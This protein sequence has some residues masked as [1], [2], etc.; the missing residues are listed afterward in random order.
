MRG[1]ALRTTIC[2]DRRR[3]FL[4]R[5]CSRRPRFS[6]P[7]RFSVSVMFL[8][9][10]VLFCFR[11]I[12]LCSISVRSVSACSYF[13]VSVLIHSVIFVCVCTHFVC[14]CSVPILFMFLFVP[15]C[16]SSVFVL[17]IFYVSSVC[18]SVD[19]SSSPAVLWFILFYVIMCFFVF[20]SLRGSSSLLLLIGAG[21]GVVGE[22]MVLLRRRFGLF[23]SVVGFLQWWPTFWSSRCGGG[24]GSR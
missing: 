22:V 16:F 20:A 1:A 21:G 15:T 24:C 17:R 3:W 12:G 13:V 11:S 6:V 9:V 2:F 23:A 4:R 19:C 18:S 5:Y 8:F 7:V 14:L 10:F